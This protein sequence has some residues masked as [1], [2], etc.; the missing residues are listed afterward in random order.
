MYSYY[1]GDGYRN[2]IRK[3]LRADDKICTDEM[4]D[5]MYNVEAM[6]EIVQDHF[7]Q[8][9]LKDEDVNTVSKFEKLQEAARYYLAGVLCSAIMS[10]TKVPPFMG[11]EYKKNWKKK[12]QRCLENGWRILDSLRQG[13][14]DTDVV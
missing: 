10:R 12:R 2:K 11:K 9:E 3:I 6:K 14:G 1:L 13:G 5:A 4:I 8:L 7:D